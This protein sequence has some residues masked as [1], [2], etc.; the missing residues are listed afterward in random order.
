MLRVSS[1][2]YSIQG[3]GMHAGLA[4]IFVRLYGCNLTCDFC[5]DE[6][7][8]TSLEELSFDAVAECIS[9][10]PAKRVIITGGEPTIYDLNGFIR[11]LHQKGYYVSIETNGYDFKRVKEADWIT[12]SPKDWD[13]I[14]EEGYEELKFIVDKASPVEKILALHTHKPIFVQPQNYMHTPNMENV[15]YCVE[16]VKCYPQKLRLSM[17]M[18][19]FI[20]VD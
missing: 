6:L 8:K 14:A 5:D 7:H 15:H 18:H 4:S 10:Y 19:K 13:N 3:E 11:Y 16:L 17:Q 1:I 20:G 12:Y 9:V 2:F